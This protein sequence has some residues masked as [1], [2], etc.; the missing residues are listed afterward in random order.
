VLPADRGHRDL[1]RGARAVCRDGRAASGQ[2]PRHA[3]GAG[4]PAAPVAQSCAMPS[5]RPPFACTWMGALPIPSCS[6]F[7]SGS[8]SSTSW[9]WRATRGWRSGPAG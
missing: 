2:R 1:R 7:S 9:P 3:G 8:R 4:D 6:R 5:R